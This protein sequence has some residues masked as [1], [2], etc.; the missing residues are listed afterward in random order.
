MFNVYVYNEGDT[1]P[2]DDICYLITKDGILLKKKVGL[3]ESLAPVDKISILGDLK[4]TAKLHIEKIPAPIFSKTYSFFKA[5]YNEHYSECIILLYYNPDTKKYKP[6]V[7]NQEVSGASLEYVKDRTFKNHML[8]G[9]IHSHASMSAFHSGVDKDDEVHWDGLHITL[10]KMNQDVL[11]ISASIVANGSRFIVDPMEYI[12]NLELVE[13][14]PYHPTHFRPGFTVIDGEKQYNKDVKSYLGYS[15]VGL[16]EKEKEFDKNWMKFV[17]KK[18]YQ[19]QGIGYSK[20]VWDNKL[21]KLVEVKVE[22]GTE[23][24]GSVL[25]AQRGS[26]G[27]AYGHGS[28]FGENWWEHRNDEHTSSRGK[29]EYNPCKDCIFRDYKLRKEDVNL[30]LE[31][32]NDHHEDKTVKTIDQEMMELYDEYGLYRY[33]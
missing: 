14:T 8:M 9:S 15:I 32:V 6:Y 4:P 17:K 10:G 22:R 13:Y 16:T 2:S 33:W 3:L 1:L 26:R 27:Y 25:D 24:V 23:T 21:G 28:G 20:W 29:K 12:E 19:Y 5:V 11:D 31:P 18:T 7:P 30:A